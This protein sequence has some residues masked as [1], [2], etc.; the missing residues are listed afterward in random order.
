MI[1]PQVLVSAFDQGCLSTLLTL[2]SGV[3]PS[4]RSVEPERQA[5]AFAFVIPLDCVTSTPVAARKRVLKKVLLGSGGGDLAR[6]SPSPPRTSKR[7][8]DLTEG[9]PSRE[10][11]LCHL[12]V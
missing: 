3:V 10:R 8:R 12:N 7:K 5:D 9:G 4:F 1:S 6:V 2:R 11:R